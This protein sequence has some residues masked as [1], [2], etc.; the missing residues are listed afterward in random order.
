MRCQGSEPDCGVDLAL[1]VEDGFAQSVKM[2]SA[3]TLPIYVLADAALL[4]IHHLF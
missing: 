3:A 1:F 2:E 4:A